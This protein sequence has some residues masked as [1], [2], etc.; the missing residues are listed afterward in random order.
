MR[1]LIATNT[2]LLNAVRQNT[3]R[4]DLFYRINVLPITLPALRDDSQTLEFWIEKLVGENGINSL[5]VDSKRLLREHPWPGN[6]RQLSNVLRRVQ[7]LAT[8][9][10]GQTGQVSRSEIECAL[11]LER[12]NSLRLVSGFT[13]ALAQAATAYLDADPPLTQEILRN[14]PLFAM[15]WILAENRA[16]GDSMQVADKLGKQGSLASRNY[17]KE[18]KRALERVALVYEQ[19]GELAL[20][21]LAKTN[22]E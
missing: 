9:A 2:D 19:A 10:S 8:Q 14:N 6:L 1:F 18:F 17:R 7:T 12:Q 11:N 3:F 22:P 4:E 16:N 21:F 5:D 15:A 20:D 13:G